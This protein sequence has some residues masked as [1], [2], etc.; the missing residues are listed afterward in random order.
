[1]ALGGEVVSRARQ[2]GDDELS[3][4][5]ASCRVRGV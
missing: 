1:M 5:A 2:L 3:V 4:L